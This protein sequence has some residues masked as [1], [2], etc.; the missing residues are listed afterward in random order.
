MAP[1]T[2]YAR[3]GDVN[4]AYQVHGDKP[5]DLL[6]V[7]AFISHVEH[8]WEDPGLERFL[9][10]LSGFARLIIMD[11]R[12]SGLSDDGPL[13]IE[14]ELDDINAVLD[15]AG[16]ERTA[17]MSYTAG[18]PL[19][20]LFAA[21][22]PERVSA[23]VLYGCMLR[24]TRDDDLPWAPTAHERAQRFELILSNWG[25]GTNGG[26]LAP[27]VAEEPQFLAWLA[28]LERLAAS[29]GRMR[30]LVAAAGEVDVRPALPTIRVPTLVLHRAE[31]A[32]M[33]VRHSREY[34]KRIPGARL[35]EL[36]GVDSLPSAGDTDALLGEVEEF[37][38]GGRRGAEQERALLTVLF[39][40]IVGST[41]RAAELGDKRWRD[42]LAAHDSEV[43]RT[44][45]RFDGDVVKRI[46]DGYLAVFD[47]GPS[48]AVRCAAALREAVA[49]Q[50]VEV[51]VGLHTGECE[52]IGDDIGGMAVHIAARVGA[53]AEGGEILVSGTTYGTVVGAGLDFDYRGEQHLKGVPGRWPIFALNG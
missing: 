45:R 12:G 29:P 5:L 51:R 21:R 32:F 14:Y 7:S 8:L 39:S 35:V 33:D 36:P 48:R 42:L 43:T 53:L 18:G 28:R 52:I 23:L 24:A 9:T 19:A 16:S 49:Q 20:A 15:A 11:R 50:G 34:A 37:L 25:Q 46:G 3:N 40:D 47:G 22:F 10:R 27:S 4:L 1:T 26:L 44:V 17:V 30:R 2:V 31:D 13:D 41:V 6:F 38:T